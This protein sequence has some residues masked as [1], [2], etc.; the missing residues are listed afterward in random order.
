LVV[1]L[2]LDGVRCCVF[3]QALAR[4]CGVPKVVW[5]ETFYVRAYELARQGLTDPKIADALGVSLQILRIWKSKR[6]AFREAIETGRNGTGSQLATTL[7]DWVYQRLPPNLQELWNELEQLDQTDNSVRQLECM[8]EGAGK[9]ARQHLFI[10]A[11][12]VSHFNLSE[13]CRKV[14]VTRKTMENWIR[15]D[16][17]FGELVQEVVWH[18]KNF[19]EDALVRLV[20]TGDPS[21][22]IFVNKTFNRD[23]GYADKTTMDVTVSGVVQHS[24]TVVPVESLGLDLETRKL[25]LERVRGA[26]NRIIDVQADGS[27]A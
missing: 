8:L 16:P 18:K 17:T 2:E 19:F 25:L 15:T 26:K 9:R 10:H 7:N 14:N 1:P 12:V 27:N 6:P 5:K 11:L 23:R 20:A 24:H 21:A 13:A 3:L 4:E 22:V